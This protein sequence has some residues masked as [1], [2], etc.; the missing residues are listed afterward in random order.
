[1]TSTRSAS[2][3][4]LPEIPELPGLIELGIY[5]GLAA[6]VGLSWLGVLVVCFGS[7]S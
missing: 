6:T 4:G 5:V 7:V 2:A 3:E 1:M